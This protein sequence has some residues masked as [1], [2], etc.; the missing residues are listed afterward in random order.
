MD[1]R[2]H[3]ECVCVSRASS[4]SA[5]EEKEEWGAGLCVNEEGGGV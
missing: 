1:A 5:E 4:L 3:S 2:F